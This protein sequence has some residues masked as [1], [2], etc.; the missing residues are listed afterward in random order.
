MYIIIGFVLINCIIAIFLERKQL[1][2]ASVVH[3]LLFV[4]LLLVLLL[5][6]GV[7]YVTAMVD[8]AQNVSSN[9][10]ITGAFIHSN[11]VLA[12]A[13]VLEIV[14]LALLLLVCTITV[15]QAVEILIKRPS[16]QQKVKHCKKIHCRLITS[17][18]EIFHTKIYVRN[19]SY[20]C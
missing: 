1:R 16:K 7:S 6:S 19:C 20:I 15:V 18:D 14:I 13:F 8:C 10:F 5:T 11:A 3:A 12:P 9:A 2:I 4:A 17:A